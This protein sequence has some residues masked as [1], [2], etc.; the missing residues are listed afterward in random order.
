MDALRDAADACPDD[1][2]IFERVTM[3]FEAHADDIVLARWLEDVRD[4]PLSDEIK[5]DA[6]TRAV[7][8]YQTLNADW[9]VFEMIQ[10]R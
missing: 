1:A 3:Q 7:D 4:R 10:A 8:L 2:S 6:L 9:L 5:F